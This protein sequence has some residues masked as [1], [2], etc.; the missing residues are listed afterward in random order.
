MNHI[1]IMLLG[2][3]DDLIAREVGPHRCILPLLANDIGLV[4]LLPMHPK[5][6]LIAEDSH[7][8]E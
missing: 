7:S 1:D 5:T 8:V 6:I 3:L 2:N 4:G